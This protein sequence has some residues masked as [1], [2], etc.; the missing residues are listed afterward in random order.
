METSLAN[1][2]EGRELLLLLGDRTELNLW[3]LVH[4]WHHRSAQLGGQLAFLLGGLALAQLLLLVDR[5]QDQL[6][7]VFLQALDVLLAAFDGLVLTA[8]IDSDS[9]SLGESLGQT[10]SLKRERGEIRIDQTDNDDLLLLGVTS[11]LGQ[12]LLHSLVFS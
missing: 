4:N 3:L 2:K 11:P 12:S 7:A 9:D 6:A 1:S 8:G 5:E 10:S